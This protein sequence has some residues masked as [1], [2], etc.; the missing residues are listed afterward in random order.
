[1]TKAATKYVRF[2]EVHPDGSLAPPE[3]RQSVSVVSQNFR[4]EI[5][6][7]QGKP[8]PSMGHPILVFEK[9]DEDTFYYV[10]L[11]PDDPDHEL[12]QTY[13]NNNYTR[14]NKK[15]RVQMTA[16]DL[17]KIWPGSPLFL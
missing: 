16:G 5:G 15:L 3:E 13:L 9:A 11:M 12:V 14:I 10:L 7:A 8:Y 1:M 17:K 6:A 4:F 2:Y